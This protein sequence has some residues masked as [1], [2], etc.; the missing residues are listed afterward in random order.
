MSVDNPRIRS[1]T[2]M[3]RRAGIM[4]RLHPGTAPGRF[5]APDGDIEPRNTRRQ[6]VGIER[7]ISRI[8]RDIRFRRRSELFI[9]P[10]YH[11]Y[12]RDSFPLEIDTRA[13]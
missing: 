12:I 2:R 5:P 10:A 8:R 13:E 1:G 11:R 4:R 6:A 3:L 7:V 9:M